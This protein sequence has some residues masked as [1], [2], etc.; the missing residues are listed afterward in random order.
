MIHP[1]D[2]GQLSSSAAISFEP[3]LA[4]CDQA[5]DCYAIHPHSRAMH[6]HLISH[7]S[8]HR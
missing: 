7:I 2:D 6:A 5:S 1:T 3:G 4:E 8:A